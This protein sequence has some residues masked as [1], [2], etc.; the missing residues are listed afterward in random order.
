MKKF[1]LNKLSQIDK[2]IL[3]EWFASLVL[4]FGALLTAFDVSPINKYVFL[5]GNSCFIF[6]AYIWNKNSMLFLSIVLEV[7]YVAGLYYK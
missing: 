1:I 7:I 2:L 5:L 4:V 3:L 6:L